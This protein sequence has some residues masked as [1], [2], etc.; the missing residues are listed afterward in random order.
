MRRRST[1]AAAAA[2]AALV[3]AAALTSVA[4][5]AGA[6]PPAA[7]NCPLLPADN[8]WHSTVTA[9]PV[10]TKSSTYVG[11]MGAGTGMHA[12]F[13][14]GK[15]DGGP[16][17]IP[18]VV[19]PGTQPGVTVKFQYKPESDPGPYPIPPNAPIEGGPRSR[20]DRHI[21]IV[22]KDN[23]RLYELFAAYPQLDG[24]WH[25][26]S[27]AI[28]DMRSNALRPSG[29]TSADAAGLPILPGLVRYDE[30]AAGHIDHAIRMTADATQ[31]TFIWP[32]RHQ[33]GDAVTSEPPMGLRLRLKSTV[34]IS[35]FSPQSKIVLQ[36][37]KTYGAIIA[38]NGSSWY[39]SGVPDSRWDND[40]LHELG[41]ITGSDFEAVDESSF[42]V[43]PDSGQS[44]GSDAPALSIGD[45]SVSEGD[46]GT[47]NAR[48]HV[49]LSAA[50]TSTITA[51]V[52]STG[53]TATAGSDYAAV[54]TQVKFKPGTTARSV[55][56]AVSG[57]ATVEAD[58]T[59][60]LTLSLPL[61][62]VVGD[63]TGVL[64]IR[65]DD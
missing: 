33:A 35:H 26:G 60:I 14:A 4:P 43:Q 7:P 56:V 8:I 3:A 40:D 34:D 20:G 6:T 51:R 9:L 19:V 49:T 29:W 27:G 5:G 31:N 15:W 30:V 54:L 16:I 39:I 53:G 28:Y 42:M 50:P 41:S 63:A 22:D 32:A 11:S 24:T 65:N 44:A 23:C 2:A 48:V 12:D 64:T 18:Y 21:L 36:A 61:G 52:T 57:D 47:T 45:A 58:E 17:G 46:A 13:G 55:P 59:V 37:L 25:A 10:H 38:D 62:A 1:L